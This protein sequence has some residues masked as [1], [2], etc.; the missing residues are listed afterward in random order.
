M[1]AIRIHPEDNVATLINDVEQ[2]VEV[3][4]ISSDGETVQKLVAKNSIPLTHKLA[5]EKIEADSDVIKYGETI[6]R[7]I[8][9]IE[10]GMHVHVHN[11]QSRRVR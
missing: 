9:P 7:S 3:L 5:L 8:E 11:V 2:G 4:I 1:K 6:G 10:E